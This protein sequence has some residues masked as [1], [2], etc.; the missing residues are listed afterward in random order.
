MN[1]SELFNERVLALPVLL[2]SIV[3]HEYSH[4]LVAYRAGDTTAAQAGRL[5][6]NPLV[7]LDPIGTVL[8]PIIQ[9][10][11]PSGLPLIG[12]AKPVPVNPLRFRSSEWDIFVS[13]AGPASNF[14]L[15]VIA[16]VL[17]KLAVVTGM[18]TPAM[19]PL[20]M[21]LVFFITINVCLGIFNLLPIPPLDGSHVLL[22]LLVSARSP[23]AERYEALAPY[24]YVILMLILISP[25]SRFFL[26]IVGFCRDLVFRFIF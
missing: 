14:L 17:M 4:A 23:L 21:I 10:F 24:G 1:L 12:W 20:I 8:I 26:W 5:T 3:V 15:V 2:F 13:L 19:K 9:F 11:G 22:R 7:H 6:L 18:L 16:A 25:A